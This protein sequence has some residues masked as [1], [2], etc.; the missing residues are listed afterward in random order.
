[1]SFFPPFQPDIEY[2]SMQRVPRY[3]GVMTCS[4]YRCRRGQC[5]T[6]TLLDRAVILSLSDA[7]RGGVSEEIRAALSP[8]ADRQFHGDMDG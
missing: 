8:R 1:M 4:F 3:T 6:T 2:H 7:C 5:E